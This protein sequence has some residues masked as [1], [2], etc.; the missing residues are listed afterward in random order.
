MCLDENNLFTEMQILQI[1]IN[2]IVVL[3]NLFCIPDP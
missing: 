3:E 1:L 2:S